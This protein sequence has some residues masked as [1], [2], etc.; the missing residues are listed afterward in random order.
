MHFLSLY[1]ICDLGQ[2]IELSTGAATPEQSVGSP[3]GTEQI[4][5]GHSLAACERGRACDF[6]CDV[7]CDVGCQVQCIHVNIERGWGRCKFWRSG[8]CCRDL[9][10]G[11][12]A[13]D[14]L[15]SRDTERRRFVKGGVDIESYRLRATLRMARGD[16]LALDTKRVLTLGI[17]ADGSKSC[18]SACIPL[19]SWLE[20]E[21]DEAQLVGGV[22]GH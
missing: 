14:E 1:S 9:A 16:S 17:W 5:I 10:L 6:E 13:L 15:S 21:K 4:N 22:G 11:V 19:Y 7:A 2:L 18:V 12:R 8:S 20:P 3:G